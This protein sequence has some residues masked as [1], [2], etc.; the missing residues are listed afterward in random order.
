MNN[1]TPVS[2]LLYGPL[3]TDV[4]GFD[5]LAE[6]ALDMRSSWNHA[7]D[8]VWRQLDPELWQATRNPWVVLQTVSREK[9][10]G[11]LAD[12]AFRKDVGD[13]V[14]ARRDAAR[15]PAW[16]QQTYPRPPLTCAA[17]FSMEFM[18]SEALP[19]YSGGLGNVAGDQLKAASDLGVPV[20]G[21]GLLYQQGYF[22]QLIDRDGAQQA[23]YPYNDP[24]QLPIMPLRHSNGEWLRI[25]LG[26]PGHPIW[27]EPAE[28]LGNAQ[29]QQL[30]LISNQ[31]ATRLHSQLDFGRTSIESKIADREPLRMHPDDAAAH[32][33]SDGDVAR[34]FNDRGECLAGVMISD[35][36]MPGVV[37]LATGAW[38][39]PQQPGQPGSLDVH[40]NPNL[41]PLDQGASRLAQLQLAFNRHYAARSATFVSDVFCEELPDIR[42]ER[43][44]VSHDR[45]ENFLGRM[46]AMIETL[47]FGGALPEDEGYQLPT[48][49]EAMA[50]FEEPAEA[51]VYCFSAAQ[52]DAF[53]RSISARLAAAA[54]EPAGDEDEDEEGEDV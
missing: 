15:A 49:D 18:L 7:T 3:H 47:D 41:L 21:V 4:E 20:I 45:L 34:L 36:L 6:L 44:P 42:A 14:Q 12:P 43:P 53:A 24:G 28:W 16:F 50:M 54:P 10:Q 31:P 52:I 23:L 8:Q 30:H 33:L 25:Q 5:A 48:L 1:E 32:G 2:Q 40:G 27:L 13:L 11:L 38:Y 26:L 17:Y 51:P 9:L 37:Q 22:R 29:P 19:I 35:D 39:D 46:A